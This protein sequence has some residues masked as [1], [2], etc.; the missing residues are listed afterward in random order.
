MGVASKVKKAAKT[1]NRKKEAAANDLTAAAL[2]V[3]S[4][5]HRVTKESWNRGRTACGQRLAGWR[6]GA[7]GDVKC[8]AEGCAEK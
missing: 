2:T 1:A 6:Y 4:G 5:P 7:P 8:G 3:L